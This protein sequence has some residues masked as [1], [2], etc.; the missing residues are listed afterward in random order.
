M[1]QAKPLSAAACGFREWGWCSCAGLQAAPTHCGGDGACLHRCLAE[2][3]Q[4]AALRARC[5]PGPGKH[6]S[7]SLGGID[8]ETSALPLAVASDDTKSFSI[9]HPGFV[10]HEP[11]A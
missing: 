7:G 10:P 2:D 3:A 11:S 5:S 1:A 4:D 9:F 6:A 8:R